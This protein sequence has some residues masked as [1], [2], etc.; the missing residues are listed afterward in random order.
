MN[1]MEKM[2]S[3]YKAINI[4]KQRLRRAFDHTD[5]DDPNIDEFVEVIITWIHDYLPD[6][7]KPLK[8]SK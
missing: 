5:P 3:G 4:L 6:Q 2:L 1:K 8:G 7:T